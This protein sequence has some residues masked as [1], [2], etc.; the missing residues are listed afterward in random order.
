MGASQFGKEKVNDLLSVNPK[1][2][3]YHFRPD[4]IKFT[5]SDSLTAKSLNELTKTSALLN[6]SEF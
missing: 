2:S 4:L 5:S 3:P 1:A 6:I